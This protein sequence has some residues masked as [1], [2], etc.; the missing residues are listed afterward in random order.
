MDASVRSTRPLSSVNTWRHLQTGNS[1]MLHKL[2]WKRHSS[3]SPNRRL[4]GWLLQLAARAR[5]YAEEPK[6]AADLQQ[7]GIC[8]QWSAVGT[9]RYGGTLRIYNHRRRPFK[10]ILGQIARFAVPKGHLEDFEDAVSCLT[11]GR[12]PIKIEDALKRLGT[13]IGFHSE[14]PEQ[15]YGVGPGVPWLPIPKSAS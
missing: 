1:P 9:C 8:G 11:P 13:L 5:Y 12:H 10:N 15:E 3:I 2:R 7:R 4:R 14:R 6:T